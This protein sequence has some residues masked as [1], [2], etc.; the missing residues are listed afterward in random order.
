MAYLILLFFKDFVKIFLDFFD[1]D[2]ETSNG[3][4]KTIKNYWN[5]SL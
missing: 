5:K 1:W 4:S 2:S 3:V